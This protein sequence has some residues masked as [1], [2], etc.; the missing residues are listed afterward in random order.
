[1]YALVVA[2]AAALVLIVVVMVFPAHS[3]KQLTFTAA[4]RPAATHHPFSSI[5][6]LL[7][8]LHITSSTK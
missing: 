6:H 2:A 3:L 1:M 5:P 7:L 4:V 8:I